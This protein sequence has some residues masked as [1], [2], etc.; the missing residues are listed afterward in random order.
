MFLTERTIENMLQFL[1]NWRLKDAKH[2]Y[3]S[4]LGVKTILSHRPG[5]SWKKRP[6]TAGRLS[7]WQLMTTH[8]TTGGWGPNYK[9]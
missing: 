4:L 5:M 2:G 1:F 6:T 3:L 8:L 7:S 9:R